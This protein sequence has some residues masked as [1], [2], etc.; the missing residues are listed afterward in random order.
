MN[1]TRVL[2]TY[3]QC[4]AQDQPVNSLTTREMM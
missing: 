1:F 3:L 4:H 2:L